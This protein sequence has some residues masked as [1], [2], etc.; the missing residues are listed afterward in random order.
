MKFFDSLKR[1]L[2][3]AHVSQI[4]VRVDLR[5]I[6]VFLLMIWLTASRLQPL[7]DNYPTS[8]VFGVLTTAALF[9][10]VFFHEFAH[11][12]AARRERIEVFEIVLH[13]FGGLTRLHREP[14]TPQ[15]E[16]RIAVAG[17][18]ASFVLAFL[19][20]G[21]TLIFKSPET[22]ILSQIFLYLCLLNF[23]LAIFNLFPGY[24][25]DGGRVLRSFLWK[26]GRDLN[27]ATTLTGRFGQFIGIALIVF[28]AVL[29]IVSGDFFNGFWAGLVGFFLYDAAKSIIAEVNKFE[30]LTVEETMMLPNSVEP[31]SD[32]LKFVDHV[33][34][35]H[36]RTAFPVAKNRQLYGIL[37]LEDLKKIP[38]EKWRETKIQDVMRPITP[39]YFVE[40][41]IPLTEAKELMRVNGI[42]ALGVIDAKG[43]LVGFLQRGRIRKRN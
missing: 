15:A 40:S 36:R 21:L 17:P 35:F 5:W 32:V 10:S 22:N 30:Q 9:A 14:P 25:L 2:L 41:D 1:Q 20:L 43:N 18:L 11:A 42:G 4:P 37:L 39:D 3:I 26:R 28:G 23:L 27:E 29:I 38:R 6:F 24:P 12:V 19:F 8:I 7:T 13:P 16:F 33:L 34:P 31:D